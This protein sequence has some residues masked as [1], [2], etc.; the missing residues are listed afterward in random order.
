MS[1]K[2]RMEPYES[3]QN[4]VPEGDEHA[5]D[6]CCSRTGSGA[7]AGRYLG[8]HPRLYRLVAVGDKAQKGKGRHSGLF[9]LELVLI[10]AL[11]VFCAHDAF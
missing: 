3:R 1:G 9:A 7:L 6:A 5:A 11:L 10:G 8:F 4:R 2:F